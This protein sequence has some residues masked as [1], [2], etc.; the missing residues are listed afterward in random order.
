MKR[1]I[2]KLRD[3]SPHK[4]KVISFFT[5]LG[6]TSVILLVWMVSFLTSLDAKLAEE[7]NTEVASPVK[8]LGN[9]FEVM[10]R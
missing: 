7:D 10:F 2:E 8:A 1:Y 4:K 5:S 6:I 9:Q 3:E